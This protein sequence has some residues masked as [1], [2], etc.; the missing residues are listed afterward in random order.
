MIKKLV[1]LLGI[2]SSRIVTYLFGNVWN[3]KK[4]IQ[5]LEPGINKTF[6]LAS[7]N[8]FFN[9][10]GSWVGYLAKFEGPPVFPHG[11]YGI[12]ISSSAIIG[13]N[14]VI[15]HQVTIGSNRLQDSKNYGAP[16]IGDNCFIGA[17][18]KII[19]SVRIGNNCRIGANC[20]VSK[21]LPNNT[22]VVISSPRV[23]QKEKLDNRYFRTRNGVLSYYDDG[24][25]I[26]E[27]V[28]SSNSS[29]KEDYQ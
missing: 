14:A 27:K 17:G 26:P 22:V 21:D 12:Y 29:L 13:K 15:F 18:A 11:I 9:R 6:L 8:A 25:W 4:T 19:G 23:I 24:R 3:L 10:R 2:F 20:A 7:Y 28:L 16:V 1:I 5:R